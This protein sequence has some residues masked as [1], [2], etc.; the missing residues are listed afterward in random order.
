MSHIICVIPSPAAVREF[1]VE[2]SY[3]GLLSVC[4]YGQLVLLQT[5]ICG[6]DLP[7]FSVFVRVCM[8][9]KCSLISGTTKSKILKKNQVVFL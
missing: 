5:P 6:V 4:Y 8:S 2:A 9:R 3:T 7:V 1:L